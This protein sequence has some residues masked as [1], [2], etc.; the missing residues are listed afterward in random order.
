MNKSEKSKHSTGNEIIDNEHELLFDIISALQI[1]IVNLESPDENL[2]KLLLFFKEHF[3]EENNLVLQYKNIE[4]LKDI[5]EKHVEDH[6]EFE[7]KIL[8]FI[9]I[10]VYEKKNIKIDVVIYLRKWLSDHIINDDVEIFQLIE[11]Y[12]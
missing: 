10:Y 6:K 4:E 1:N 3:E 12:K 11:K 2:L 9:K 5:I 8:D 7:K